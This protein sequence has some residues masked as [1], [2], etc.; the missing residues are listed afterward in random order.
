MKLKK[1]PEP[2]GQEFPHGYKFSWIAYNVKNDKERVLF[3]NHT[4]KP[5]HIHTNG[6][7]EYFD[8]TSLG[9]S[10]KLFLTRVQQ[11]FGYFEVK[12]DKI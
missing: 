3:D 2:Y 6:H 7:K 8:W 9:E 10:E 5:P 11:R 1:M 4:N 12:L